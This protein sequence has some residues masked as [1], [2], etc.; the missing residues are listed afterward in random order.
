MLT[1]HMAE[2]FTQEWITAWNSHDLVRIL[3][4]YSDD[5]TM[6]S[7]KIAAIA[8]EPTGK[9]VGKPAVAA[10]WEKALGLLPNLRFELIATFI[11]ADCLTIHYHGVSGPVIE[12]FFFNEQGLVNRA[13]AT[14]L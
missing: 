9:L 6:S 11:G 4:H 8:G 13:A 12:V 5:F 14:Y 1:K 2:E 10:Y 7:P 3:S